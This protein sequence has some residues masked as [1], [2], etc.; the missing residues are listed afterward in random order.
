MHGTG[1]VMKKHLF[2]LLALAAAACSHGAMPDD[3][4]ISFERNST[5]RGPELDV[6]LRLQDGTRAIVNTARDSIA[7]EA[8]TS[9]IPGHRAQSWTML[10]DAERGASLVYALVS[11]DDDNPADYLM[12]GWWAQF[13]GQHPPELN[14]ADSERYGIVDGPEIDPASPPELPLTGRATYT[15]PAG[16]LYAYETADRRVIDEYEGTITLTADFAG[17]TLSGCIGCV[18][19]LATRRAHFGVFLGGAVRDTRGEARDY[20]MHLGAT[21]IS[22]AG[23][24]ESIAVEARHPTRTVVESEGHWGGSFS[25]LP[26]RDGDPRLA[27]GFSSA[28]FVESD[29]ASGAFVGTFVALSER[30]KASAPCGAC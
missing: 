29:G 11:W 26:D 21:P 6:F 3:E 17:G 2:L 10:K 15:G 1:S 22:P 18:G 30:F 14:L 28:E 25:N 27:A 5:F 16:G 4:T 19:D 20:E 23:T 24:F 13:P 12:A 7:T 8:R 9:V